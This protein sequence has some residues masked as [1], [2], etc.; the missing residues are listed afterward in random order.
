M[1]TYVVNSF[2]TIMGANVAV[3]NV[4]GGLCRD[5][6]KLCMYVCYFQK[7][8]NSN[9]LPDLSQKFYVHFLTCNTGAVSRLH[10]ESSLELKASN[11]HLPDRTIG[12]REARRKG[13]CWR[14]S[15]GSITR[16]C[17]TGNDAKK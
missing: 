8:V 17:A 9:S 2:L 3:A 7:N 1:Y 14:A 5:P 4:A 12:M 6:N 10:L 11:M 13:P 16:R 15:I